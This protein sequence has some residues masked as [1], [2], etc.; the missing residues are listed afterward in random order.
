M[1][2]CSRFTGPETRD[3]DEGRDHQPGDRRPQQIDQVQAERDRDHDQ[4]RAQHGAPERVARCHHRHH[5]LPYS[6]ARSPFP[7][8]A[9]GSVAFRSMRPRDRSAARAARPRSPISA[10][11][12]RCSPGTSARRCRPAAAPMRAEQLATLTALRHRSLASDELGRLL[13]A[14]AA[15]ARRRP[16]ARLFEASLVRVTRRDWDK[17]RRVPTELRAEIARATSIAEHAWEAAREDVGLRRL[18]PRTSSGWSSSSAATS[19]ASSSS[20]PTTRCS[21]TSSPG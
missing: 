8:P 17:A 3:R 5:S 10:G 19:S 11:P 6:S 1:R 14:A 16:S 13:D 18:P 2:R 4:H 20:T 21:T 9:P 7:R 15:A 12:G